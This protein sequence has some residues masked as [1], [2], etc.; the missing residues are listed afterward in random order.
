MNIISLTAALLLLTFAAVVGAVPD[1]NEAERQRYQALLHELRCVVCQ[2]Q[3]I[4]ESNAP[5][6]QDLREQVATQMNEGRSNAEIRSYLTDRYGDFV[7]Y[8]PPLRGRT[9]ALWIGPF[10]LLALGLLLAWRHT[11]RQRKT[12]PQGPEGQALDRAAVQGLL[13]RH[14]DRRP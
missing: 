2:N 6:A 9:V 11:H 8:K 4:A 1:V 14:Q 7:L 13:D 3:S 12:A 5:L 10:V